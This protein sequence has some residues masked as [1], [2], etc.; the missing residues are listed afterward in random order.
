MIVE[1][2]VSFDEHQG[3]NGSFCNVTSALAVVPGDQ[4]KGC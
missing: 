2:E 1:V 4:V 3:S